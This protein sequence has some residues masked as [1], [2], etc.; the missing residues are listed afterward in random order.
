MVFAPHKCTGNLPH[1]QVLKNA[2]AELGITARLES[3]M[4]TSQKVVLFD[5]PPNSSKK[6]NKKPE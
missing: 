6:A 1:A 4:P 3:V 5:F 2:C